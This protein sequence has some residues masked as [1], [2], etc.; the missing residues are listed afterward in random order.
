MKTLL[1]IISLYAFLPA[2]SL[3]L[4]DQQN[5]EEAFFTLL[6]SILVLALM[7]IIF[8]ICARASGS[9]VIS[10]ILSIGAGA[11]YLVSWLLIGYWY[12]SGNQFD[13]L[14][15]LDVYQDVNFTLQST[16]GL[17]YPVILCVIAIF[18][19][20]SSVIFYRLICR[21]KSSASGLFAGQ[22]IAAPLFLQ[23][24][25]LFVLPVEQ[26][27]VVAEA[28]AYL[29][30]VNNRSIVT[31][32]FPDNSQFKAG[33]GKSVFILQIES[34]NSMVLRG[35]VTI[36]GRTYRGSYM[37]ELE[38]IAADGV[39]IPYFWSNTIQSNR[40]VISALCGVTNNTGRS[41]SYTPDKLRSQCAP[42]ILRAAG[43]ETVF[44]WAF[45]NPDFTNLNTLLS[46]IGF[47]HLHTSEIME[48]RSLVYEWGVDDCAFYDQMFTHLSQQH[49]NGNPLF[50]YTKVS[51]HHTP[52]TGSDRYRHV[53]HFK[54]YRNLIEAYIN[55]F[56]QQDYCVARFY[57]RFKRLTS[58]EAHLIIFADH[59]WPVGMHGPTMLNEEDAYNENFLVP[60]IYVPPVSEKD[61]YTS[62]IELSLRPSF[63][64]LPATLFEMLSGNSYQNS[65]APALRGEQLHNYEDCHILIQ[66]YGGAKIAIVRA[67]EK[68]VYDVESRN[69][70]RYDLGGDWLEENPEQI[71]G[72]LSYKELRE[73][74]YCKRYR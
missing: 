52:F 54:P 67:N 57:E 27:L 14:Y 6:D 18:W 66:P 42:E 28:A 30:A 21:L 26:R 9:R 3:V 48:D 70:I 11:Y 64:D 7:L 4:L 50:V 34:G 44:Y 60:F 71:A 73:R 15:A 35:D 72:D 2:I 47:E 40:S 45:H 38:K 41:L 23:A 13:I 16:F 51:S 1:G 36:G 58:G 10:V 20:V 43:Y 37:P 33:S 29:Q 31:P 8:L 62:G 24:I 61:Y 68:F 32:I 19:I 59:S 65:F 17:W 63:T 55:S 22:R 25:A 53:D 49:S 39:F 74:Y 5:L 12:Y 46:S 56:L 69:L